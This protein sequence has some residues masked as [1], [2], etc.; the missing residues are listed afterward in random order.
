[1]SVSVP[2]RIA[3]FVLQGDLLVG[4]R[5]RVQCFVTKG[6]LPLELGWY[7][8]TVPLVSG[9]SDVVVRRYDQYTS[10]LSID[11]LTSQHAGN[12]TCVA[13]NAAATAQYTATLLVN[14]KFFG[15][16]AFRWDNSVKCTYYY[17]KFTLIS[18]HKQCIIPCLVNL[19][20]RYNG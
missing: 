6:D 12:Y 13:T 15:G 18:S 2:P 11:S 3:P 19:V 5:V 17:P 16:T 7:K 20:S 9:A 4:E 14:G 1:M 10:S 8:D